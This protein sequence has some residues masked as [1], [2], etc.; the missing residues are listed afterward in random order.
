M[1][2]VIAMVLAT[3]KS[4]EISQLIAKVALDP[5]KRQLTVLASVRELE[6]LKT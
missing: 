1:I 5:V 4:P 3:V 6:S 2:C